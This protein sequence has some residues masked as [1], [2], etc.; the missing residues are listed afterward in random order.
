M[1]IV[2]LFKQTKLIPTFSTSEVQ[3]LSNFYPFKK[4]GTYPH[5][6]KIYYDGMLFLCTETAYQAAKTTDMK[7]RQKISQ[8]SPFEAVALSKSGGIPTRLDWDDIKYEIMKDL[9]WQKFQHPELKKMLLKTKKAIL[10]E[11][12]TRGDVYWG[13]CNGIGQN[14]LGK[15]LME[16]RDKLRKR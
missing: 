9:V 8:M 14:N 6:L 11:G 16:T 10:Q 15:I 13:I 3:F 4:N 1:W 12:N 7:L 5:K 2:D